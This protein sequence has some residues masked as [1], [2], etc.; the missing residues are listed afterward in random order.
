M[1][2]VLEKPRAQGRDIVGIQVQE[3]THLIAV[4]LSLFSSHKIVYRE[5]S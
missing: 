2:L 5:D 1:L 3:A 4:P